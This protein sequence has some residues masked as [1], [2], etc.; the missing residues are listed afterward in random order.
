MHD[1]IEIVTEALDAAFAQAEDAMTPQQI[2]EI[3]VRA[4]DSQHGLLSMWRGGEG[5]FTIAAADGVKVLLSR[6]Q[7]QRFADFVLTP[8]I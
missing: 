3:A 7:A 1:R 4:L 5:Q 8:N 6:E 2:A